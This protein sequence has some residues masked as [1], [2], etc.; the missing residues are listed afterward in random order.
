MVA[1]DANIA[2]QEIRKT[3]F[4]HEMME[5]SFWKDTLYEVIGQMDPWDIDISE[6]ATEYASKVEQMTEMNFKIPAN[7]VIVTAVLLRMK[8]DIVGN[9]PI[10]MD[11]FMPEFL[12][13]EFDIFGEL[14]PTAFSSVGDKLKSE[15]VDEDGLPINVKPKR[16]V[17]RRVTAVELINAIQEVLEEK[18]L[19]QKLKKE[20]NGNGNGRKEIEIALTVNIQELIEETYNR[21][22]ELI[23][24]KDVALFSEM[25]NSLDEKISVF[26]SLLYL[27]NNQRVKLEQEKLYDE[28]F[29]K[30][31]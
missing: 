13:G 31:A 15:I 23:S 26:L 14:D 30:C 20:G 11:E 17:K 28:I 27:S 8:A 2:N 21:V 24:A 5:S 29:I 25:A 4:P 19:R 1:T 10:S 7:V 3:S 22:M 6:L 12:E 9:I 18:T 16:V